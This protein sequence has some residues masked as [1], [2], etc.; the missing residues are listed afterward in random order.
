MVKVPHFDYV[1]DS[2]NKGFPA[3]IWIELDEDQPEKTFHRFSKDEEGYSSD[4]NRYSLS[5]DFSYVL[6][7]IL[8]E[9]RDCDGSSYSRGMYK[10]KISLF[11]TGDDIPRNIPVISWEDMSEDEYDCMKRV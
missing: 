5:K 9:G 8:A 11:P 3:W 4:I 6:R 1:T 10:A 2:D 7:L